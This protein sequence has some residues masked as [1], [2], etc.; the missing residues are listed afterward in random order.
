MSKQ[1]TELNELRMQIDKVDTLIIK[2]LAKRQELSKN[3]AEIKLKENLPVFC[4]E[5]EKQLLEE[6][7]ELASLLNIDP[8][9]VNAI[10]HEILENS[11]NIQL[12]GAKNE[13]KN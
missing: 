7:Q 1:S 5:R 10:F 13:R 12:L 4:P 6:R 2:C 9:F 11:K 3:I 8:A